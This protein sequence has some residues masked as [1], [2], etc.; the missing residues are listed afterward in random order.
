MS[1]KALYDE[2]GVG[3]AGHRQPDPRIAA[4]LMD[5]LGNARSVVNVGAGAGSYEPR[6]RR[7]FAVEPSGEMIRQRPA[8]SAPAVRGSALPLP[9]DDDAF[10]AALAVLT[11]HHWPDP[12][13]GLGELARVAKRVVLLTFDT[14]AKSFWLVSDYF[15]AIGELDRRNMPPIDRVREALVGASVRPL[16]VPHDCVDGFL[17][18]YWRRPHAYLD[19]RVRAAISSFALIDGVDEG[20]A[21]L[22]RDLEDGTWERRNGALL[23]EPELDIGYRIVVAET[24]A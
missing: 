13:A 7:V 2:I 18:A 12:A 15:P 14:A 4:Q 9:F 20:V 1:R 16:P 11:I 6:D 23:D 21:R 19:G 17:G 24:G 3:Y 5:A 22:R 8:G 10:D